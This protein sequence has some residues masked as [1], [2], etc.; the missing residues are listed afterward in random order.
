[1]EYLL[2]LQNIRES[3]PEILNWIFVGI[4]EAI[5]YLGAIVSIIVYFCVDKRAGAFM[6]FNIIGGD[7]AGNA[8]KMTACVYRP[9][10]KYPNIY[11][12]AEVA[13]SATGYSFPSAHTAAAVTT[14]GSI[15]MLLKKKKGVIVTCAIL[16]LLTAFAR[17][18]LGCHTLEDVLVAMLEMAVVLTVNVFAQRWLDADEKR[19]IIIFVGGIVISVA[20]LLFFIFKSYPM[21][22]MPD[23]SLIVDPVT[24]TADGY[25]SLGMFFAWII[26]WFVERR[27]VNFE[28]EGT[29][30]EKIIR[31]LIVVAVFGLCYKVLFKYPFIGF[32]PRV[33]S[34]L[35]RFLS[36]IVVI[37]ILPFFLKKMQMKKK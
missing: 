4:S 6:G 24:L 2:F 11:P 28:T 25:G 29:K 15:A 13:E 30:K 36:V 18:Y 12:A 32:D 3:C 16:T 37:G 21:D 35:R 9:W 10:I 1:M 33:Y 5:V 26:G 8:L 14:Y 7:F 34:F 27:F 17:N 23:G 20:A 22:Y 19:D 31:A